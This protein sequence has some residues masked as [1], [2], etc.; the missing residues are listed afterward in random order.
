MSFNHVNHRLL[1][2]YIFQ[3]CHHSNL[4]LHHLPSPHCQLKETA[5]QTG[6]VKTGGDRD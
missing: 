4:H 1:H 5:V 2:R 6:A 3:H